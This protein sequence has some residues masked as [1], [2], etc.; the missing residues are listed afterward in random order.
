MTLI[1]YFVIH[2]THVAQP[3]ISANIDH[4]LLQQQNK[5]QYALFVVIKSVIT[6]DNVF[7]IIGNNQLLPIIPTMAHIHILNLLAQD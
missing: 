5:I 2:E 6:P 4:D 1:Q 3:N 7:Q